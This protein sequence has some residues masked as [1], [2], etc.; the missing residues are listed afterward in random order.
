MRRRK[1]EK[2]ELGRTS[3]RPR[4]L[5]EKKEKRGSIKELRFFFRLSSLSFRHQ[6]YASS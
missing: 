4:V 6:L 5:R 2:E 3:F 1:G